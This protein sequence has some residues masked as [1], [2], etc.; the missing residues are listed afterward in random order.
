MT[1]KQVSEMLDSDPSPGIAQGFLMETKAM[2]ERGEKAFFARHGHAGKRKTAF[3]RGGTITEL[4]IEE[5]NATHN[6]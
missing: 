2:V 4:D 5:Y 1:R 6:Y 3:N